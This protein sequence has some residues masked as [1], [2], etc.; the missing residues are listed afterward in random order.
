MTDLEVRREKFAKVSKMISFPVII[1]LIICPF[2]LLSS[3]SPVS[4]DTLILLPD[5]PGDYTNINKQSPLSGNHYDK[6]NDPLEPDDSTLVTTMN[7]IQEK[8]VYSLEDTTQT[9]TINHVTVYF[10]IF[11]VRGDSQN[12]VYCQPFLRLGTSETAGTEQSQTVSAW[13]TYSQELARPGGGSWSWSDIN[14]LQVGIGLRDSLGPD[15]YGECRCTLAYVEVDY[16][17][18]PSEVWVAPPPVGDDS[19]PGTEAEPFATIHMGRDNVADG[20]TIHVAAGTYD[21]TTWFSNNLTIIGASA[22]TTFIN[23]YPV[24]AD[25]A[26]IGIST[27]GQPQPITVTISGFTIQNGNNHCLDANRGGG[28]FVG[29]DCTVYLNN[30]SVVNNEADNG[31]GIYN[32]GTLYLNDCTIGN[33]EA[34]LGGGINNEGVLYVDR[35]CI[36]G[37]SAWNGG[38]IY[39]TPGVNGDSGKMWL[40]NCTISGNTIS[41]LDFNAGAGIYNLGSIDVLNCTI[42]NNLGNSY[43]NG[44]GFADF[45]LHTMTFKNTIVAYNKANG[46]YDNGYSAGDG[47]TSL[48]HNLDSENSCEFDQPTDKINTDPLLSPL[49][50]NGGPTFTHA[51]LHG[52]PAIDAG[53]CAGA[54]NTDQRGVP[55][56]QGTN[57]DIGAYELAQASVTTST[58]TGTAS[59]ST[60]NGYITDLTALDESELDC[61]PNEDLDFTHGLFSFIVTG[62]TP[63]SSVTVVIILPSDMPTDTQYWKCLNGQWVDATSIMGSNDGDSVIMLTLTDGGPF[64]ADG[65]ANGTIIDPGGPAVI[66]VIP[67][68]PTATPVSAPIRSPTPKPAQMAVQYLG[69]TPQQT[70]ANQPVTISTNVVNT[71]DQPGSLNVVLEINGKVEQ[72]KLVSLGPHG[73]QPIKFTVTRAQPG[74]YTVDIGGQKGSFTINGAGGTG[75]SDRMTG[76]LIIIGAL[77]LA[78]AVV[79]WLLIRHPA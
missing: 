20:G 52:S 13:T 50:D 14:N 7:T 63:G 38:G 41:E 18:L 74:T 36:S 44:G 65:Q 59:F 51:L 57:C 32:S 6:V 66:A 47:V 45:S 72:T 70:S 35:C 64:D 22:L 53:T 39:N 46:T 73:T 24:E 69:I 25:E 60:L 68:G 15:N 33:N 42:A 55:R 79:V 49:Q 30:C 34:G 78:V 3:P 17:P 58:G 75:S 27:G 10:R 28:V 16:I 4:A 37:N 29:E 76:I 12:T 62:I 2:V 1:A 56:P 67:T 77:V 9:G 23:H 48:G 8:D 71:G 21:E 11:Y 26:V 19:N 54:P 61:I 43:T 31:G 5:G 40:T